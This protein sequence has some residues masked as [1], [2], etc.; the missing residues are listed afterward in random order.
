MLLEKL[1]VRQRIWLLVGC[2]LL[3]LIAIS[4]ISI[5]KSKQQYSSLKQEKYLQLTQVAKK[6]IEFFYNK[7]IAGEITEIEA[8]Q[9]AKQAV[10]S[11]KLNDHNYFFIFHSSEMLIAHPSID[12]LYNDD[13]PELFEASLK[14]NREAKKLAGELIGLERPLIDLMTVIKRSH[15]NTYTGMTEYYVYYVGEENAPVTVPIDG[16]LSRVPSDTPTKMAFSSYFEPWEWV[17]VSVAYK[18]DE[19]TAFTHWLLSLIAITCAIF[20]ILLFTAWMISKSIT[21]PL[22]SIVKIMDDISQGT[23]DLTKKLTCS[24]CNEFSQ[25]SKSFNLFVE[26]ISDIIENVSS[27]NN[28]IL[29]VSNMMTLVMS[30]TVQ[31]SELQLAE[32]EMLASASTELSYSIENVAERAKESSMAAESA[33]SAAT[34]AIEAMSQNLT[35]MNQLSEALANT[36]NEVASMETFSNKVSSVLEVIVAIAEQTNLLALNA[37][38]EAAR[39]GEQGRGFAVVADE[40]RTLAQRTQNSTQEINQII[41]DLQKGTRGVVGSMQEGISHSHA[42][43]ESA[44]SA[45]DVFQGV[46]EHVKKITEM[47]LEIATAVDE[48]SKVTC[49]I[50]Q[51]SQSIADSSKQN[52]AD[53]ES[54]SS[55]TRSMHSD[56][57]TMNALVKQ[58]KV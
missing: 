18:D 34:K 43:V 23:G 40:V 13:T 42:C 17:V 11:L 4:T 15:P 24:G 47:N 44:A 55:S 10:K 21:R 29:D 26:K 5:I 19:Q 46:M 20:A 53:S 45:N 37:A 36:Q 6:T 32:T 51:S 58:F 33:E 14:A 35:S 8:R 3:G 22:N 49:E 2:C 7:F 41:D 52:L 31:R 56:A 48:Q 28:H 50:A 25:L 30:A 57:E 9:Q 1:L 39:A 27:K 54:N 12:Y 38:I 16:D